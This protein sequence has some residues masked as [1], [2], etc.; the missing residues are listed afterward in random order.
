ML[1]EVSTVRIQYANNYKYWLKFF[2]VIEYQTGDSFFPGLYIG[3]YW[4]WI[5]GSITVCAM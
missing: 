1:L 2:H 3:A 4:I 5:Y